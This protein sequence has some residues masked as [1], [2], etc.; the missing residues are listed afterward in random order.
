MKNS[1]ITHTDPKSPVS[2][3]FR[4]LRT[5]VH[6]TNIDKEIRVIQVTSSLQSEG[7]STIAANYAITLVQSGKKVLIIDCDLRR[8]NI[9]RVFNL[10]NSNGLINLLIKETTLEQSIKSTEVKDLYAIVSGPIPPNPSEMLESNRMREL[11]TSIKGHFDVVI[12]DSPP[13]IPVTDAMIISNLVDGT[14]VTIA[15]GQ[16]EREVFKRTI[17][18]LENVG[19]NIIGTVVNKVPTSE[20]YYASYGYNYEYK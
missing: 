6:F 1:I 16:I 18:C 7:K 19:A 2:E 9:H 14:L 15:L 12:I 11:I 5:N 20:R 8:P 13:V 4:S 10:P 17:E 3:A